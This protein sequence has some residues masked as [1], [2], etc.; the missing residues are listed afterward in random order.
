MQKIIKLQPRINKAN[1]QIN[2]SLKKKSL[3]KKYRDKL[4]ELKG[5]KCNLSDFEF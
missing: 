5:I 3:P 2:F 1:N 4:S